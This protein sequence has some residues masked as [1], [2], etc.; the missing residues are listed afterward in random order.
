MRKFKSQKLMFSNLNRN[1]RVA[2][3][4]YETIYKT[5]VST[6]THVKRLFFSVIRTQL[7]V[8]RWFL[9]A[10]RSDNSTLMVPITSAWA[11]K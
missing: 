7:Q 6:I 4:A 1:F 9:E 5:S 2:F 8:L 10:M 3:L 11:Y